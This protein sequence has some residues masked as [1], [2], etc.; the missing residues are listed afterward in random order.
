MPSFYRPVVVRISGQY[1]VTVRI[2]CAH[3]ASELD[4]RLRCTRS[5]GHPAITGAVHVLW[6]YFHVP[7]E[8]SI[9]NVAPDETVNGAFWQVDLPDWPTVETVYVPGATTK[10]AGV[11]RLM[12]VPLTVTAAQS[13]IEVTRSLPGCAGVCDDKAPGNKSAAPRMNLGVLDVIQLLMCTLLAQLVKSKVG[14]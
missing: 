2:S 8:Q 13:G 11:L 10:S 7:L 14:K 5:I 4:L 3:P 6:N 1:G 9:T 12:D